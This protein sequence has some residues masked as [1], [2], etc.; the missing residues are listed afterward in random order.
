M[1]EMKKKS[2]AA[3][4]MP[5]A[6]VGDPALRELLEGRECAPGSGFVW[7]DG[8]MNGVAA[9]P[10]TAC[11][12]ASLVVGPCN[13]IEVPIFGEGVEIAVDPDTYWNTGRT[14]FRA[15]IRADVLHR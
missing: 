8:R 5:T 10:T 14:T 9:E 3:K 7:D 2:A 11:P 13:T 6:F 15:L 4:A 12:A 1:R